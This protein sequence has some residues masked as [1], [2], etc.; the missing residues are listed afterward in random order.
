LPAASQLKI[1]VFVGSI[2][3]ASVNAQLATALQAFAPT[4]LA[5]RRIR[6]D[7]LPHYNA[8]LDNP[9]GPAVQ[10]MRQEVRECDALL[11]VTPEYNRSIPGVLKNAIDWGSRPHHN[12]AFIGKPAGVIGATPGALGTA[13][14]Q[15][16]LRNILACLAVA[17]MPQPDAFLQAGP[18]FFA[19]GGGIANAGTRDF[20]GQWVACYVQWVRKFS[21]AA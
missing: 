10:R 12:G 6:I 1:G 3:K 4:E 2:R 7:D 5:F 15:Q 18:G 9:A 16:H 13:N 21:P 14:A 8:D 19:D 11:F 20:L 17:T